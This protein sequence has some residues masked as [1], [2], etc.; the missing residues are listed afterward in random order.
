MT[1]LNYCGGVG[2]GFASLLA[3]RRPRPG[4]T[5]SQGLAGCRGGRGRRFAVDGLCRRGDNGFGNEMKLGND[6]RFGPHRLLT[7]KAF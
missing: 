3:F 7:G 2:A 5:S 4:A 1:K 6:S